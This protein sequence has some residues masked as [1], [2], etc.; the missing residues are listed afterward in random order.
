MDSFE[1]LYRVFSNPGVVDVLRR[2]Y[3]TVEDIDLFVGGSSEKPL[4]SGVV[5]PTFACIIGE[6]FRRI[7]EGD[8]FWYENADQD[9]SFTSAQLAEIKKVTLSALLCR[10]SHLSI[11]QPNAFLTPTNVK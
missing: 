3:K 1:D 2:Q 10:N 7:R 8:R 6:Q 5:G 9:G 11:M 4:N